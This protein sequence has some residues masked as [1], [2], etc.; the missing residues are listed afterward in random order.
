MSRSAARFPPGQNVTWRAIRRGEPQASRT[1]LTTSPS[2][3]DVRKTGSHFGSVLHY[4]QPLPPNKEHSNR[5]QTVALREQRAKKEFNLCH[6]CVLQSILII[7]KPV[8]YTHLT[9]PTKRIV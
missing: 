7:T 3:T 9:L 8:S 2:A 1:S 6:L 4:R 5:F